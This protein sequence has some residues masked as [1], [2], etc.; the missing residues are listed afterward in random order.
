MTT[1]YERKLTADDKAQLARADALLDTLT[2][3]QMRIAA[4]WLLIGVAMVRP[5]NQALDEIVAK[6]ARRVQQ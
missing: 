5:T 4:E 2:P 1:T 6:L 3:A